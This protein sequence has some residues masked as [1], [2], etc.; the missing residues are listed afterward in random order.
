MF[1][2]IGFS[3]LL[4]ILLIV[5]LLFGPKRLPEIAQFLGRSIHAF[6]KG[7]KGIE[8]DVQDNENNNKS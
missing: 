7:I 3:E 2:N 5:L 8:D 4:V 6:K 1:E